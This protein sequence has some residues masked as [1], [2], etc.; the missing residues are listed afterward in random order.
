MSQEKFPHIILP[1]IHEEKLFTSIQQGSSKKRVPDRDCQSHADFLRDKLTQAWE[2][3]ENELVVA[4]SER[5]G[6]Y[7][8]FKG[9]PGFELVTKSLEDMNSKKIRLCNVRY[10][11][12]CVINED[13]GKEEVL[14]TTYA[15]VFV[16]KEKRQ[17]FFE[18][19][20]K[21]ATEIDERSDK[22]KNAKLIESISEIKKAFVESFW[23]DKEIPLPKDEPEWC[24]VWLSSDEHKII[25]KFER[26]L[27]E[28]DITTKSGII[29]FPERSVKVVYASYSQLEKLICLSDDIAEY[30]KAKNTASF[31]CSQTKREQ[32]EWAKS[33]IERVNSPGL[34]AGACK[35]SS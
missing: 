16:A 24:E 30:R 21:Y 6:I 29:R 17:H 32:A 25:E 8:E 26:L 14:S 13:T 7:L 1:S 33:L 18:K 34:K 22:P 4:H 3:A 28:Q 10:E 27:D 12:N 9:E 2:E 31:W 5:N 19:I 11:D 35:S 23:Q 20:E 15:T